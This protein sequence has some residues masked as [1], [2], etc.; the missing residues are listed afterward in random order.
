MGRMAETC[1]AFSKFSTQPRPAASFY[2]SVVW[3][4]YDFL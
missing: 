2:R 4:L 3:D 1:G